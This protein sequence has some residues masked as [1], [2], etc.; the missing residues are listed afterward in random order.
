MEGVESAG[1]R[2]GFYLKSIPRV[3]GLI[4]YTCSEDGAFDFFF[5]HKD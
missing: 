3:G 4:V 2:R 1:N 5:R